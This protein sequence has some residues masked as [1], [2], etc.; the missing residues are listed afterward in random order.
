MQG[1]E[2]YRNSLNINLETIISNFHYILL[3]RNAR[4]RRKANSVTGALDFHVESS[5]VKKEKEEKKVK[6]GGIAE[7]ASS[8][9]ADIEKNNNS[10]NVL[11]SVKS[12]ESGFGVS[13]MHLC[14]E[15]KND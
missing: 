14:K 11:R 8:E 10:L 15:T 4:P 3:P 13:S 6:R 12:R 9:K 2:R 7:R 1:D 5:S